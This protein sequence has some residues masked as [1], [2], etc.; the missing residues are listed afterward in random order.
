MSGGGVRADWRLAEAVADVDPFEA[1]VYTSG[2]EID[3]TAPE[4]ELSVKL[5]ELCR[6][7]IELQQRGITCK[8]KAAGQN[9]NSCAHGTLDPSRRLSRL[10]RV[11]KDQETVWTAGEARVEARMG[12]IRAMAA[13]ADEMSEIGHLDAELAEILVAAGL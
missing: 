6:M 2:V 10:C 5:T 11:G 1:V 13:I 3:L 7:E 8:L 12:P 4:E 9:C